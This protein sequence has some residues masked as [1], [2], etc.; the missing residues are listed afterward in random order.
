MAPGSAGEG[1]ERAVAGGSLYRGHLERDDKEEGNAAPAKGRRR[2]HRMKE[3]MLP[4][5]TQILFKGLVS[6]SSKVEI[7]GV[8]IG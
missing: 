8:S 4:S 3:A 5:R 6:P 7:L 2:H 1:R